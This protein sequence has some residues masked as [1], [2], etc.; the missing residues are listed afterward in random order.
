VCSFRVASLQ[1]FLVVDHLDK[2]PI[3]GVDLTGQ[4]P[5]PLFCT[6]G[7]KEKD[8]LK[9][10]REKCKDYIR[11]EH[12]DWYLSRFLIARKWDMS[13]SVELFCNAMKWREAEKI[14]DLVDSFPEDYWYDFL[15]SYWPTSISP[16]RYHYTKDGVSCKYTLFFDIASAP[17]STK[18]SVWC[19][20]RLL[21]TSL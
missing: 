1:R 21:I 6:F 15:K 14:D 17:S 12:S 4:L 19:L 18:E 7:D 5:V 16:D 3:N 9:E 8:A 13:K 2:Y 10:F 11:P 20:P